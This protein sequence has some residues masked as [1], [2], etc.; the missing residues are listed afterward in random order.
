MRVTVSDLPPA[1]II[2]LDHL[3]DIANLEACMHGNQRRTHKANQ[4]NYSITHFVSRLS[5][6]FLAAWY[7]V[8]FC[9]SDLIR[10]HFHPLQYSTVHHTIP[11]SSRVE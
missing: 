8:I 7:V 9:L 11:E 4:P 5:F 3:D 2:L 1:G 6:P 10:H